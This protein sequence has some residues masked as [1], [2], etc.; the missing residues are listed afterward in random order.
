MT[1]SE[2]VYNVG[3]DGT[4]ILPTDIFRGCDEGDVKV[5]NDVGVTVTVVVEFPLLSTATNLNKLRPVKENCATVSKSPPV[6]VIVRVLIPVSLDYQ[7]VGDV[8]FV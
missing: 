2:L 7:V 3:D 4:V 8:V 6:F 5:V 1:L